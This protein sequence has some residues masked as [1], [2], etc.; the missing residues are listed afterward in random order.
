MS[1]TTQITTATV[2]T[3]SEWDSP[4]S[5]PQMPDRQHT[6]IN[7]ANGNNT[8]NGTE[9]EQR[10]R[11]LSTRSTSDALLDVRRTSNA[12]DDEP[13]HWQGNG[14]T[15]S[16][17]S[18]SSRRDVKRLYGTVRDRSFLDGTADRDSRRTVKEAFR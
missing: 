18:S 13:E 1:P 15:S 16:T 7:V 9:R 11:T 4:P 14:V 8:S 2:S 3:A 12:R 6:Q 5:R 10:R 17:S